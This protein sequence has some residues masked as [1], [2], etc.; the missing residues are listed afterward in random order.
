[1]LLRRY[2]V[3]AVML[4]LM[5]GLAGATAH[6]ATHRFRGKSVL[7][8]GS[9]TDSTSEIYKNDLRAVELIFHFS[10]ATNLKKE[11]KIQVRVGMF[12]TPQ[13]FQQGQTRHIALEQSTALF[14]MIVG[15]DESKEPVTV[16]WDLVVMW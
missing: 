8:P 4:T 12:G 1:M 3:R 16:T 15:D 6:A 2:T 14:I 11:H 7:A 5:I 9:S 10:S 13:T